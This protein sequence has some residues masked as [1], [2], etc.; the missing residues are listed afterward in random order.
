M[1]LH[2]ITCGSPLYYVRLEPALSSD[3]DSRYQSHPLAVD[4]HYTQIGLQE[5]AEQGA[6][7]WLRKPSTPQRWFYGGYVYFCNSFGVLAYKFFVR[8]YITI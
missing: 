3:T 7:V 2:A 4:C 6:G 8:D 5:C 1:N